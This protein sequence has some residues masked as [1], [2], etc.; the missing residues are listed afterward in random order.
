MVSR[1][2]D[3]C[4]C[5]KP[6]LGPEG[7]CQNCGLQISS[8]QIESLQ[9]EIDDDFESIKDNSSPDPKFFKPISSNTS[10]VKPA[11]K[12]NHY[13]S[14]K[15]SSNDAARRTL[16]YATLFEDIGRFNQYFNTVIAVIA[17]IIIAFSDFEMTFKL[18]SLIG[19]LFIW[20]ILYIQTSLIRGVASY[21]QMK[22]SAHLEKA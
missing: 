11:S 1:N 17:A 20:W 21:F 12:S 18:I 14:N 10:S 9:G 15:I 4:S 8:E 22:A 6:K 5:S 3:E 16:K 2:N 7:Y 13:V 19:I